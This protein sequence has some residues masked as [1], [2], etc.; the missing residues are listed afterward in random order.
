MLYI[1]YK[2]HIVNHILFI[3][4]NTFFFVFPMKAICSVFTF[5]FSFSLS[6]MVWSSFPMVAVVAPWS[7]RTQS[8]LFFHL[9]FFFSLTP[10]SQ[11]SRSRTPKRGIN[12]LFF[13]MTFKFLFIAQQRQQICV[14]GWALLFKSWIMTE[15][16][17]C[18]IWPVM[19][20]PLVFPVFPHPKTHA[21]TNADRPLAMMVLLSSTEWWINSDQF[22]FFSFYGSARTA[23]N[24]CI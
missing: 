6:S 18:A 16:L 20:V 7:I 22:N 5:F 2:N 24:R 15:Y 11:S 17:V 12:I 23:D 1:S 14:R 13:W 19:P 21:E 4:L 10:A 3:N 8:T 9:L